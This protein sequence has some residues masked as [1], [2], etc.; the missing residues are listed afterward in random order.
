MVVPHWCMQN[1]G[2]DC[3][4]NEDEMR[5]IWAC[6]LMFTSTPKISHLLDTTFPRTSQITELITHHASSF[7]NLNLHPH[8]QPLPCYHLNLSSRTD[9]PLRLLASPLLV[10]AQI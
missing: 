6:I 3:E 2:A 10:L 4:L 7:T 1:T 9:I 5:Y 8:V